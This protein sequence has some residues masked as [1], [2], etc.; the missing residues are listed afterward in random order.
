[1]HKIMNPYNFISFGEEINSNRKSREE[2][3]RDSSRLL[4]GWLDVEL[5]PSTPLIIP[6]GAHPLYI[7]PKTRKVETKLDDYKKKNCHKK[8]DFM[9]RYDENGQKQYYIPGSSLR[10]MIRSVYEAATDSCVPFLLADNK[11]KIDRKLSL[12]RSGGPF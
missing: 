10:G 2:G 9:W 3:Y 11:P 12:Y 4:S 1:M 5:I 6:D 7:D 8:Y